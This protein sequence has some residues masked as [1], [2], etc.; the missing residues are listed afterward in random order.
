M[1]SANLERFTQ[2]V[3]ERGRSDGTAGHY[4]SNIEL[5]R[6]DD[7]GVIARLLDKSLSPNTRRLARASLASWAD[8]TE[9]LELAKK[10]KD[11]KLPPPRR[12]TPKIPLAEGDWTR[13][14]RHVRERDDDEACRHV[15]LIM[16]ARGLRCGDVLRIE[17]RDLRNARESGRLIFEAKGSRRL[18]FNAKPILESIDALLAMRDG[19]WRLV[20][21]LVSA[22]PS[23]RVRGNRVRRYLNRCGK[24]LSMPNVYPHRLRR[25][26][27]TMFLSELAGDP[28]AAIKLQS[29]MAWANVTTALGYVDAVNR[30]ELDTVGEKMIERLR[31]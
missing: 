12:V 3:I 11:L 10:L 30:D 31:R 5:C 22:S 24:H 27:A 28:A 23:S 26:Y 29:H 14:V 19:K 17:K 15:V 8:F 20:G 6:D 13:L 25:T 21:E 1:T 7:R 16:A 9:D 4:R 2:W 18:D